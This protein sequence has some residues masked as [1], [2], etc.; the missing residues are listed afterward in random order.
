M[1][2]DM[3]DGLVASSHS[4][5]WLRA[6]VVLGVK[7]NA[8]HSSVARR[9][10]ALRALDPSARRSRL[11]VMLFGERSGQLAD[12]AHQTTWTAIAMPMRRSHPERVEAKRRSGAA[13]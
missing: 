3:A 13:A 8:E 4:Q 5:Q 7:A 2:G 11:L 6:I 10:A 9:F 1:F 12:I